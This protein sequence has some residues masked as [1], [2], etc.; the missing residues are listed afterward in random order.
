MNRPKNARLLAALVAVAA[1]LGAAATWSLW[2]WSRDAAVERG[3]P[4]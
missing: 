2:D 3:A 1:V 4:R